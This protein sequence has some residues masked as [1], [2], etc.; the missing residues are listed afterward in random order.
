MGKRPIRKARRKARREKVK[1]AAMM[2][3]E[4]QM[5]LELRVQKIEAA[6]DIK[7]DAD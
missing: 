2:L 6:L 4:R 7:P 1:S 3:L 5:R